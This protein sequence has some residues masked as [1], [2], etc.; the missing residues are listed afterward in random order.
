M[1]G[2]LRRFD[3]FAAICEE[4]D[5]QVCRWFEWTARRAADQHLL[6][7]VHKVNVTPLLEAVSNG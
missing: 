2:E 3:Y 6:E 5:W 4:C 7:H 1:S